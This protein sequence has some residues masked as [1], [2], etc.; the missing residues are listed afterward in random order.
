[1]LR[2]IQCPDYQTRRDVAGTSRTRKGYVSYTTFRAGY[3][4]YY[5]NRIAHGKPLYLISLHA[6]L[7]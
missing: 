4:S 6:I 7:S 3:V 2:H 1:M 5:G